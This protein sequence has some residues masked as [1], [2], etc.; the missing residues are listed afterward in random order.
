MTYEEWDECD[1][2]DGTGRTEDCVLESRCM[3]CQGHGSRRYIRCSECD[4]P[5]ECSLCCGVGC[6]ECKQTGSCVECSIPGQ[7]LIDA[8]T[9]AQKERRGTEVKS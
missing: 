3:H 5:G 1:A 7:R 2:C 4:P 9:E 8:P 6:E